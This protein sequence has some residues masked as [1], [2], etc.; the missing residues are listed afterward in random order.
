MKI[1]LFKATSKKQLHMSL[2]AGVI[3]IFLILLSPTQDAVSGCAGD[4]MTCHTNLKG[5]KE[6]KSLE[7]C[8]KCHKASNS[9]DN[10]NLFSSTTN[11]GC[12]DRCFTCHNEWPKDGYHASLNTCL[13]CHEK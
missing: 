4:C 6:H 12:G 2:I 9:K 11:S 5:S 8:I 3:T 7:T 13:T 1:S 10:L